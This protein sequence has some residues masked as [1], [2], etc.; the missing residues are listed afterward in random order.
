MTNEQAME[1]LREALRNLASLV[2]DGTHLQPDQQHILQTSVDGLISLF[3][4]LKFEGGLA[5]EKDLPGEQDGLRQLWTSSTDYV[6]TVYVKD[7]RSV[8]T[9]HGPGCLAV[10]GYTSREYASDPYL[11]FRMVYKD[12]RKNVLEQ[13]NRA[14]AGKATDPLEHRILHKNGTVRWIRNSPVPRYDEKGRLVAYDGLITDITQRKMTEDAVRENEEKYRTL[15]ESSMQAIFLEDLK[16]H[17]L[18]CNAAACKLLGYSKPELLALT[19]QDLMPVEMARRTPDLTA[20]IVEGGISLESV[21]RRRDGSLVPVE[22]NTRVI[23]VGGEKRVIAFLHDLSEREQAEHERLSHLEAETRASMAETARKSLETEVAVRRRA[24]QALEQRAHQLALINEIGERIVSV[25]DLDSLLARAV[26]QIQQRFGYEHVGIFTID[27]E[28]QELSMTARSWASPR[29]VQQ[30]HRLKL[31]QGIVGWVAENREKL[32]APDVRLEPRYINF[33]PHEIN[34]LSELAVPLRVGEDILG[35]LDV[36]SPKVDAFDDNDVLVME[37]L[38]GLL[39]VALENARLYEATERELTDRMQAETALLESEKRYR[40]LVDTSPDAILYINLEGLILLANQRAAVL[41]GVS[42]PAEMLG[43]NV[44][45]LFGQQNFEDILQAIAH[46]PRGWSIRDRELTLTRQDGTHF[47]AE[48]G[49]SLV[50]NEQD[51]PAGLI[52]IA[53][54]VTQ[55]KELDQYLV[56]TERLTAMGKMSAELAHEIKN[57]L[58]S[59]QSNLELV[60][61]FDLDPQETQ[62]HLRVCYQELERL[63]DLTNRLLRQANPPRTEIAP[64]AISGLFQRIL[65][66]VDRSARDAGVEINLAVPDEFPLIRVDA[67]ELMQVLLNLCINAIEAMPRGGLLRM[68]ASMDEENVHLGVT[69]DGSISPE[70]RL[71]S[72]FEPFYTT[73]TGGTG[74][75]L[76]ISYNIVQK[77]GGSLNVTNLHDPER[78][79]FCVRLPIAMLLPNQES[80]Q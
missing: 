6:Y 57:P 23:T 72:I 4:E 44:F 40:T 53:R 35:V 55:R 62:S 8:R 19:A 5:T 78:V 37:T 58:Q 7:G 30:D 42:D 27:F 15:F 79:E 12:D 39:V 38:A 2:Q 1:Y 76:P 36:Q 32:L 33:Y 71:E 21:N 24:E 69:N 34:C 22:V 29:I 74:L 60:M 54:D 56:R 47:P 31:G 13:A 70:T 48:V 14:L 11:W 66:M 63:V 28:A 46:L 50:V 16:G 9:T 25:L 26:D 49:A 65:M 73:K 77:M 61:D 75:G 59:I 51:Q 52:A 20:Q 41:H 3:A 67:D 43:R 18:D 64:V 10:T 68:S 45:E 80:A 17:I